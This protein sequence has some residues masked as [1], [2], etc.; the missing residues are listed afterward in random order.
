VVRLTDETLPEVYVFR[1][2]FGDTGV[3]G[4]DASEAAD[5]LIPLGLGFAGLGFLFLALALFF[6]FR[7]RRFL[8][9][10][11]STTGTI[12]NLIESSGSEGGTVYQAV[13][14][15]KT[16]DGRDVTWTETMAS[17]PPAGQP[18]DEVPMKYDPTDPDDARISKPFRLWFLP[19]LFG[20]L[21]VVFGGTGAVMAIIGFATK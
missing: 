19:G 4:S 15:F 16:A 12:V 13:V 1:M 7:T 3:D 11:V 17:N 14:Q 8:E 20:L 10:A 5:V 2:P 21:G 6:W 18:G 9:T